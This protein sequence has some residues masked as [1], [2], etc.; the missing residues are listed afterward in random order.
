VIAHELAEAGAAYAGVGDAE[1][2]ARRS[3]P[4]SDDEE[5]D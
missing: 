4:S 5:D 3:K 1:E 2:R